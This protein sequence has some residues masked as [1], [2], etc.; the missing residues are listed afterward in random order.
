M[1]FLICVFFVVYTVIP[2]VLRSYK[3]F[4]KY[5]LRIHSPS[6]SPIQSAHVAGSYSLTHPLSLCS[7]PV[8]SLHLCYTIPCTIALHLRKQENPKSLSLLFYL[9]LF[10]CY[11]VCVIGILYVSAQCKQLLRTIVSTMQTVIVY[12]L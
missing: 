4:S 7:I 11:V 1:L 10:L 5:Y 3:I 2:F 9:C 12:S 8:S 6:M